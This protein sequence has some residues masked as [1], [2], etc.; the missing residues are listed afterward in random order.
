MNPVKNKL[1][2]GF[3]ARIEFLPDR[4][5]DFTLGPSVVE[6]IYPEDENR[7]EFIDFYEQFKDAI[8]S[9][10]LL[11]AD[12]TVLDASQLSTLAQE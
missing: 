3:L 6:V 5:P 12:G 2:S 9:A 7:F 1:V 10:T 8:A 4:A 11:M